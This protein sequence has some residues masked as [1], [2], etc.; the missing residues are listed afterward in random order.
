MSLSKREMLLLFIGLA[1]VLTIVVWFAFP[2]ARGLAK[3]NNPDATV[4]LYWQVLASGG[5]KMTSTSFIMQ[6]T[7]GQAVIGTAKSTSYELHSGY[8]YNPMQGFF[9]PMVTK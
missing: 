5:T 1:V 6:N 9:L 7:A 2:A 4:N 8:W 3:A